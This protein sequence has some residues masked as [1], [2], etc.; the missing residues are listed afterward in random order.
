MK[1]LL[2]AAESFHYQHEFIRVGI[3][4]WC[5]SSVEEKTKTCLVIE[6]VSG[7]RGNVVSDGFT[8]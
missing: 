7:A 4:Q 6:L 5:S 2:L 1:G 8:S 3:W